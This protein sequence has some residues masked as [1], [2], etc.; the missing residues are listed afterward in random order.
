MTSLTPPGG[1][2]GGG[3]GRGGAGGGLQTKFLRFSPREAC[4]EK[5]AAPLPL[6]RLCST[7]RSSG[8]RRR[9]N[10]RS[11]C[12]LSVLLSGFFLSAPEEPSR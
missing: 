10:K 3:G 11:H 12:S 6:L 1:I 7:T 9:N 2:P 5:N 8:S 4:R